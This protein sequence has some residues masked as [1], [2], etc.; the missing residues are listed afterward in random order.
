MPLLG[1]DVEHGTG[2]SVPCTKAKSRHSTPR[3]GCAQGDRSDAQPASAAGF[4][5]AARHLSPI[6]GACVSW[7][8]AGRSRLGGVWF[9]V[10]ARQT[11]LFPP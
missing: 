11:D 4:P 8:S 9:V 2:D 10:D 3:G 1:S 5:D 6:S 7:A